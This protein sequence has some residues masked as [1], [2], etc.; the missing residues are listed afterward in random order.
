[1][2]LD[3]SVQ[4]RQQRAEKYAY[5]NEEFNIT[6]TSFSGSETIVFEASKVICAGFTARNQDLARK[7]L[8]ELKQLGVPVP[9]RTGRYYFLVKTTS[10]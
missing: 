5:E 8:E 3:I 10:I 7:H 4:Q 2:K 1:L 6:K 9:G